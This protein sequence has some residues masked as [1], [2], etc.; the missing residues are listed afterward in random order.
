M[1]NRVSG[2]A[3]SKLKA[4]IPVRVAKMLGVPPSH[5]EM[6][7]IQILEHRMARMEA[8]E[9]KRLEEEK[10]MMQV[11]YNILWL[12]IIGLCDIC[13]TFYTYTYITSYFATYNIYLHNIFIYTHIY[14]LLI[15]SIYIYLSS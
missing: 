8:L 10:I 6:S 15:S 2:P 12:H 3:V 11:G 9:R 14:I 4:D 1:K 13:D 5:A 7:R